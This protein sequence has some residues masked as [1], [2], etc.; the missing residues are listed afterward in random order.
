ME[1]TV[2]IVISVIIK[3]GE[4]LTTCSL[5]TNV[6]RKPGFR[7]PRV[8]EMNHFS[9][10]RSKWKTHQKAVICYHLLTNELRKFYKCFHRFIFYGFVYSNFD[11]GVCVC[12]CVSSRDKELYTFEDKNICRNLLRGSRE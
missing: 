12:V 10:Y 2:V 11:V 5:T 9:L 8:R 1:I 6:I 3:R 7:E 4:C